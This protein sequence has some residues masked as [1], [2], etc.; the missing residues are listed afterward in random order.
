MKLF[1][2][3]NHRSTMINESTYNTM[4]LCHVVIIIVHHTVDR[5]IVYNIILPTLPKCNPVMIGLPPKVDMIKSEIR[6][7]NFRNSLS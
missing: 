6:I 5:W 7:T 1:Q 3:V 2:I 4:I